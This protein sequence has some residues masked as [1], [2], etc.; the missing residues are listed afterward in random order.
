[1]TLDLTTEDGHVF[2]AHIARPALAARAGL[3]VIQEI[4]GV[5]SH[6]R[7]V[8]DGY[9]S[10]GFLCVAPALF[11]RVER[12]VE[13]DYEADDMSSGMR[14]KADAGLDAPIAG[15]KASVAWLQSQGVTRIGVVGYC[16]G[17]LLAWLSA[18]RVDGVNA[19]VAY[20]GG[21]IPHH[22]TELPKCPVMAHFGDQDHWLPLD[23]VGKFHAQNPQVDLNIYRANHGF[24]CDQRASFD[25][26]AAKLARERSLKFFC[27]HLLTAV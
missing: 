25:A 6:V 15:I 9:A 7:A 11:D 12:G 20:Y 19:S 13:L 8:A 16:W 26:P 18:A 3:V 4:F 23:T 22:A 2:S 1:M 21:G 27:K 10:D 17:G 24:N 5:N 14:L